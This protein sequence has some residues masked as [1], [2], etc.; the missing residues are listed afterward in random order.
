MIMW[1]LLTLLACASPPASPVPPPG[2]GP[3]AAP[4]APSSAFDH[5]YQALNRLYDGAIAPDGL[6]RYEVLRARKTQLQGW[7]TQAAEAPVPS[8]SPEQQ[9]AFWINSYN[10]LTVDLVLSCP[11]LKSIK[12]LDQGEVWKTRTFRVGGEALTLDMIEHQRARP[13]SDGRVHAVLN[14]GAKG[15]PPFP[16]RPLVSRQLSEQLDGA[17]RRWVDTT[18][19]DQRGDTLYLSEIFRWFPEDFARYR[20]DAIPGANEAQTRAIGF[21]VTF[22]QPAVRERISAGALKLAWQPYDWALNTAP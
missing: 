4:K 8:F 13:L 10:A 22:A 6:V 7:L 14:C 17:A 11:G 16:S 18:A 1:T 2:V 15:C 3:A 12:D 20:R 21:L 9:L 19:M 5:E